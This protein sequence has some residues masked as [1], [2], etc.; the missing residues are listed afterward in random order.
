LAD[1]YSDRWFGRRRW[2]FF[3]DMDEVFR[4]MEEMMQRQLE[5]FYKTTPRDLV[6]EGTLPDG[7]KVREWGPFVY[8]YSVTIGADGKP[9]IR[10]F[11]N[12]KPETRLG[13]P[14]INIKEQREP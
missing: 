7:S 11:G 5:E 1:E 12:V 6:R 4:E 13:R 14:R 10:E 9:Q 3:S 8:E 2:P